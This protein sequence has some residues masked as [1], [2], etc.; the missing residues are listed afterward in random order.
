MSIF[1]SALDL[2]REAVP[3]AIGAGAT[4]AAGAFLTAPAWLIA[5]GQAALVVVFTV[6]AINR[7]LETLQTGVGEVRGEVATL[8]GRING[9]HCQAH[10][11]GADACGFTSSRAA[12]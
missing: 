6:R 8:H 4:G 12:S 2:G 10:A 7:K 1:R 9:L 5:L 3:A 11:C